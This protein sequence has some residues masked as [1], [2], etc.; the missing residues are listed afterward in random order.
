MKSKPS[1]KQDK[2]K[3]E[4][5]FECKTCKT[6]LKYNTKTKQAV[7]NKVKPHPW[8]N[9]SHISL[10]QSGFQLYPSIETFMIQHVANSLKDKAE[11]ISPNKL[12]RFVKDEV[13]KKQQYWVNQLLT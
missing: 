2:V 10:Y 1:I 7:L 13:L 8:S 6:I 12:E 3:T 5:T 11:D 9:K 4:Y